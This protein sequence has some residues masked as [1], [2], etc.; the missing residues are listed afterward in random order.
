MGYGLEISK[1]DTPADHGTT[2]DSG[3]LMRNEVE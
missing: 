1:S 3:R 2:D